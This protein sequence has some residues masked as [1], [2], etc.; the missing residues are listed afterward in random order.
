MGVAV[1]APVVPAPLHDAWDLRS[2]PASTDLGVRD[3]AW[4]A[5]SG[6]T[7]PT[8][9]P[10][11]SLV[12]PDQLQ[13]TRARAQA[14]RQ[15]TRDV[16][17]TLRWVANAVSAFSLSEPPP[18]NH[19]EALRRPDAEEWR[20]ARRAELTALIELGVFR[21]ARRKR[22][23]S[24]WLPAQWIYVCKANTIATT[25][26]CDS[27]LLA[28]SKTSRLVDE[29]LECLDCMGVRLTHGVSRLFC[30]ASSAVWA[31]I[32]GGSRRRRRR[33]RTLPLVGTGRQMMFDMLHSRTLICML[34]SRGM[35]FR[36]QVRAGEGVGRSGRAF[37]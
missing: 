18:R 37:A 32:T 17:R 30:D 24:Q 22:D 16:S 33:T 13:N 26:T 20:T 25:S 9:V 2:G 6:P 12:T 34:I 36:L 7:S 5:I 8:L 1:P 21:E 31:G 19:K 3:V 4:D 15:P 27:E 14:A 29:T 28:A 10:P 11:V 35:K 23:G